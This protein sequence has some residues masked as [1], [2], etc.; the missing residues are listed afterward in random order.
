MVRLMFAL[1]VLKLLS[2]GHKI[3]DPKI[4]IVYLTYYNIA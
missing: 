3:N 1:I 2:V 4:R